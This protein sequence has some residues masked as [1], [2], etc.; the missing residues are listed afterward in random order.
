MGPWLRGA[1]NKA[2]RQVVGQPPFPFAAL[3]RDSPSNGALVNQLSQG[4]IASA[5]PVALLPKL[6]RVPSA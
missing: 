4:L 2:L 5:P 1:H 6:R 3:R